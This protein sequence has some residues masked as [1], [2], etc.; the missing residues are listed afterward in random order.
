[1]AV[2]T[3]EG[4]IIY[5]A[6]SASDWDEETVTAA[7]TTEVSAQRRRC[8][9]PQ[10]VTDPDAPVDDYPADLIEACYRRVAA[11]LANRALPLGLQSSISEVGV[12]FIRT[13]GG[14]REVARLEAP[15]RRLVVG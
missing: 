12:G 10:D 6:D 13:G 9:I 7:F 4:A 8:S 3:V 1:M 5:L 11:N 15:F 14:D 2:P